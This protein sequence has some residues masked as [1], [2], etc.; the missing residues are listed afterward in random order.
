MSLSFN[1]GK[2]AI[3]K[4]GCAL[5]LLQ[6]IIYCYLGNKYP[7]CYG[8]LFFIYRGSLSGCL[9]LLNSIFKNL[10]VK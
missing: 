9:Y 6:R 3:I 1:C 7:T 10:I 4:E 2:F 5:Q 8:A